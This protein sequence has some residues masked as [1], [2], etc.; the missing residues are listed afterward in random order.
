MDGRLDSGHHSLGAEKRTCSSSNA[1]S[2]L[3]NMPERPLHSCAQPGCS[4]AAPGG[5]PYCVSCTANRPPET[6]FRRYQSEILKLYNSRR[7]KVETSPIVRSCNPVCQ[8]LDET[9]K[10]CHKPS[11][12]VH[13][14]VDPKDDISLFYDWTNLVAI[15]DEHHGNMQGETHCRRFCHTMGRYNAVY[16]HGGLYPNWHEKYVPQTEQFVVI[17][18][19][20]A[21]SKSKILAA[22]AE[23]I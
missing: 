15:C 16:E 21:V 18:T 19:H 11:R 12:V 1:S 2:R 17:G 3:T 5:Q 23:P 10:Q 13:H 7:W 6:R 14:L 8:Y 9:G 4:N 20:S 22:L